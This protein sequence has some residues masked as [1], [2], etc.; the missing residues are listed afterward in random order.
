M[1]L[2]AEFLMLMIGWMINNDYVDIATQ[3]LSQK[4]LMGA[5]NVN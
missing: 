4:T 1:K 5:N 3:R 2:I